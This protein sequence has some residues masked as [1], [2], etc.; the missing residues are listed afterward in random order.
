MSLIRPAKSDTPRSWPVLPKIVPMFPRSW[1]RASMNRGASSG[2]E[3]Q[4]AARTRPSWMATSA[5]MTFDRVVPESH[6][7]WMT[8]TTST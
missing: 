5:Y 4:N 1:T 8:P 3:S 6:A 7:R 2:D